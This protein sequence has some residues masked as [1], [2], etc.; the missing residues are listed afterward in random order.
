MARPGWT[1]EIVVDADLSKIPDGPVEAAKY[2]VDQVR[3]L[4]SPIVTVYH[5]RPDGVA[6]TY[7][8]DTNDGGVTEVGEMTAEMTPEQRE[9]Y[10]AEAEATLC[11][12]AARS[13]DSTIWS[14]RFSPDREDSA[15]SCS[16]HLG[17]LMDERGAIVV[18]H[19][20]DNERSKD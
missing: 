14:L 18:L 20:P 16:A 13:H 2:A 7:I 4:A 9:E 11:E 15:I 10:V 19:E 6:M 8:V 12:W 1:A 5:H 3:R 17:E